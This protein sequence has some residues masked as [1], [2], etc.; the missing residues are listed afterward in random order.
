M[1]HGEQPHTTANARLWTIDLR[2]RKG[3]EGA[4]GENMTAYFA[5]FDGL[6]W[7]NWASSR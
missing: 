2:P 3:F 4:A 5:V 7:E 1:A 6:S